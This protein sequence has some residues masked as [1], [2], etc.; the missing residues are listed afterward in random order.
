MIAEKSADLILG[1][2]P[3]PALA[4]RTYVHQPGAPV[5]GAPVP[6]APVPGAGRAD[7]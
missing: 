6:G 1:N 7:A 4:A 5:P 3:L 2:T